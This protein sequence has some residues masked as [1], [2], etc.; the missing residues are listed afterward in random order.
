MD[1]ENKHIPKDA[2]YLARRVWKNY[3]V[4]L[5]LWMDAYY[6][7]WYEYGAD[8]IFKIDQLNSINDLDL[9]IEAM[10]R[11]GTPKPSDRDRIE[12]L[13]ETGQIIAGILK[14]DHLDFY[15]KLLWD[16]HLHWYCDMLE[17]RTAYLVDDILTGDM[18]VTEAREIAIR[19]LLIGDPERHIKPP[20]IKIVE[21]E[22]VIQYP[23]WTYNR[24]S[25]AG[26]LIDDEIPYGEGIS[27]ILGWIYSYGGWEDAPR[28]EYWDEQ[29]KK[30]EEIKRKRGMK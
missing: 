29:T 19:Q 24:K 6:E 17:V 23:W 9:Y 18:K 8:Y 30:I 25:L 1:I 28:Q 3:I 10:H 14:S 21:G 5:Y 20:Y 13:N 26:L 27:E 15:Y 11:T 12:K 2:Q 16:Q 22:R 4:K 7:V